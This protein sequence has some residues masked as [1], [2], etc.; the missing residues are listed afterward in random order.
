LV[1]FLFT[2]NE[3]TLIHSNEAN[4]TVDGTAL[5][6]TLKYWIPYRLLISW[7]FW[8]SEQTDEILSTS[9]MFM[10]PLA[11]LVVCWTLALVALVQIQQ[12][13]N[14]CEGDPMGLRSSRRE[15]ERSTPLQMFPSGRQVCLTVRAGRINC[16]RIY[17][18]NLHSRLL[19]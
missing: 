6:V 19:P 5:T 1:H 15:D 18:L 7:Q 9:I 10:M 16:Q 14:A 11:L 4:L 3:K 13:A 8:A 2:P 12:A 17:H